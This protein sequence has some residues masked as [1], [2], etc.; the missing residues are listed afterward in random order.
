[1]A[2]VTAFE[3]LYSLTQRGQFSIPGGFGKICFGWSEFGYYYEKAGIYQV[4]HT[5]T[6]T[7]TILERHYKPTNPQTQKQQAWRAVFAS[8]QSAWRNLTPEAKA[9]YNNAKYPAN[10][11]GRERFMK[12][13]LNAHKN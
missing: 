2:F 4:R 10:M 11:S 6:G 8:G 9:V 12:E 7:A 5:K 13:Y 1:M 3:A